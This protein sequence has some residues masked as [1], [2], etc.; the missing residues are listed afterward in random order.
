[1]DWLP[2]LWHRV[3]ETVVASMLKGRIHDVLLSKSVY[4]CD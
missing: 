3:V 2:C 1:M 4:S